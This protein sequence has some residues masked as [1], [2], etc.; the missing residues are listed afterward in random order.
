M[1]VYDLITFILARL[2]TAAA[3]VVEISFHG[4]RM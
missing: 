1:S 4:N 3:S 2:T